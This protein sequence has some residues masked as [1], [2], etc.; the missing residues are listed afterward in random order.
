VTRALAAGLAAIAAVG[1][2]LVGVIAFATRDRPFGPSRV[3]E[4]APSAITSDAPAPAPS[5][6]APTSPAPPVQLVPAGPLTVVAPAPPVAPPAPPPRGSWENVNPVGGPAELGAIGPAVAAALNGASARL[7][8]CFDP[9]VEARHA[10]S[11]ALPALARDGTTVAGDGVP[12]VLF[13][14]LETLD[15]GVRIVDAPVETQ[16]AAGDGVVLC[17]QQALRGLV[18]DAPAARP[19]ARHRLRYPLLP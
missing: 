9:S 10:S 8:Q 2:A 11:G 15:G 4:P 6:P 19:G 5:A 3:I 17:A 12:A 14:E 18:L 16:G 13:L 7:A 1:I